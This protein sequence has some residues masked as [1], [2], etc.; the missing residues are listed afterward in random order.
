MEASGRILSSRSERLVRTLYRLRTEANSPGRQAGSIALGLFI[1]ATPLFGL[2]FAM[3]IGLGWLLRLNRLK[4]YLAANISNPLVAPFLVTAELQLGS[5][6]RRGR[7]YTPSGLSDVRLLGVT[8]DLAIGSLAIGG[9]LALAGGLLTYALLARRPTRRIQP[10][11]DAA[12]ER[13]LMAGISAWEFASAKLRMDPVYYTILRDGVLPDHGSLLDL[14]CGQGLMLALVASARDLATSDV[15]PPDWPRPPRSL[16]L[17]GLELRERVARRARVALGGDA[18]IDTCD[19]REAA[20]GVCDVVLALDVLHML[21]AEAQEQM[22]DRIVT[23]LVPGGL[24]VLREAD[25]AGGWRFR[26]VRWTNWL[27][28]VAEGKPGRRFHFRSAAEWNRLLAARGFEVTPARST[29]GT[30]RGLANFLVYGRRPGGGPSA[31]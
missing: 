1:G 22:L 16:R 6:L 19:A 4:V 27:R 13:F 10:V 3:A 28:A 24:L 7:F 8:S 15:W 5:W 17:R 30:T 21:P 23:A 31:G 20:L 14:G 11:L 25:A 18:E 12:A 9:V 2:H 26:V 29:S